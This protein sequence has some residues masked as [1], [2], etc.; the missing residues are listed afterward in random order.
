MMNAG[1]WTAGPADALEI[2]RPRDVPPPSAAVPLFRVLLIEDN[3]GDARLVRAMLDEAAGFSFDLTVARNLAEGL[4]RLRRSPPDVVLLDMLL[5]DSRGF[6]TFE[7]VSRADPR[8]PVIALTNLADEALGA[9]AVRNGA[10]DYLLKNDVDA[11]LLAR[12]IRYAVERKKAEEAIES[13]EARYR[14]FFETA[15]DGIVILDADTG[16]IVDVNAHAV[17]ILGYTREEFLGR[18]L[19]ETDAFLDHE[20]N[21]KVFRRL[22]ERRYVRFENLPLETKDGRRIDVEFV[23][24]AYESAGRKFIQFNIRDISE[25]KRMELELQDARRHLEAQVKERT[26]DLSRANA[27]LERE[28]EERRR[29]TQAL[30]VSEDRFRRVFHEAPLGIAILDLSWR[31]LQANKALTAMLEFEPNELADRGLADVLFSEDFRADERN[32]GRLMRGELSV[33]KT[34]IRLRRKQGKTGWANL[35]ATVIR[36]AARRPQY[37]L[38]MFENLAERKHAEEVIGLS[39]RVVR[40]QEE[41]RRWVARELHDSVNQILS[42]IKYRVQAS[43][44]KIPAANSG[45]LS[46]VRMVRTLIDQCIQEIRRISQN[47]R[48][49]ALDDLGLL[50]AVQGLCDQFRS[51]TGMAIH[52]R[53]A[54]IH[55][56]LG[57]DIELSL[58]R[59]LQEALNNVVKHSGASLV[60]I[61]LEQEPLWLK[62][63]VRDNGRGFDP[64][65]QHLRRAQA[66]GLGLLHIRERA[67]FVGGSM[68]VDSAPGRGT[69]IVVR[70]PLERRRESVRAPETRESWQ[71]R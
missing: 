13:S 30:R 9:A 40:A 64:S 32:A 43:E 24:H 3:P 66:S 53:T 23:S 36:D 20:A 22:K 38:A 71:P 59:I 62:L 56:R 61:R 51:R 35:T 44:D 19:F 2:R 52:L 7:R 41:E 5:P 29:A 47:L 10:Q 58:F 8:A 14:N 54:G 27:E 12:S 16:E 11:P 15:Q 39:K 42:S 48:P 25:R 70:V 34:E 33:A 21:R 49:T 1:D 18:K 50:P 31:F 60:T 57:T 28:L 67:E 55:R 68:Q 17:E 37:I 63:S 46:D 6:E 45:L 69:E 65:L 26:A 4:D